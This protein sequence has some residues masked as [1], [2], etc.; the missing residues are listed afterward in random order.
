MTDLE[1]RAQNPFP[2][3]ARNIG[4]LILSWKG[5]KRKMNDFKSRITNIKTERPASMV[6]RSDHIIN[7]NLWQFFPVINV[8]R[9]KDIPCDYPGAMGVPI[10]FLD[11]FS[12]EQFEILDCPHHVQL[13]SGR[14]PYR[15]LVV[16]NL[17]PDLPEYIDLADWFR[18]M[19]V[20]LDIEFLDDARLA[21]NTRAT[22]LSADELKKLE[23]TT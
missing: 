10:T 12:R 3:A 15:R 14:H 13:E 23:G 4:H 16:R 8:D 5:R 19:G 11:K 7:S 18:K 21:W 2:R 22:I 9:V 17:H 1:R 20:P 6:I